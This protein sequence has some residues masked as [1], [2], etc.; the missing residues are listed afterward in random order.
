M[1]ALSAAIKEKKFSPAYHLYGEDEYRKDDALRAL[2]DAAV[3]PSTRDFNLDQRKGAEL[4]AE[5]LASLLGMPP[6]MAERRVVVIRE[7]SGLRKDARAAL[8]RYLASPSPDLLLVLTTGA[9]D[10]PPKDLPNVES[11]EIR[12][13]TGAE[14][15]RWIASRAERLG[16]GITPEA[17]E[18]LQAALGSDTGQLAVEL[19]KLA[20]YARGGVIDEA[21]VTALVGVHREE[22]LA[23]LL[24]AVAARDAVAALAVLPGVLQQPKMSVVFVIMT[25]TTQTLALAIARAGGGKPDFFAILKSGGSN[26]TG[27]SWG[28]AAR[29]W[30]RNMTRWTQ[31]QLDHALAALLRADFAIKS[32]RV[33][34]DEQ[35]L[36]SAILDMCGTPSTQAA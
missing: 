14:L 15:P 35:V 13:H 11:V 3:D 27:R 29:A 34:S 30:S 36:A 28:D 25:L 18:L 31:P 23:H 17:T 10:E 7:F 2:V 12:P 26:V 6:M 19:D 16:T 9:D 5:T 21:V 32:S 1:R 24:D 33:S 22:T 4:D 8:D 20:A